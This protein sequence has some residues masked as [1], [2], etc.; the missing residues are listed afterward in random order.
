MSVKSNSFSSTTYA[1]TLELRRPESIRSSPW[2]NEGLE[3]LTRFLSR[4]SSHVDVDGEDVTPVDATHQRYNSSRARWTAQE[5][6]T[7][8]DIAKNDKS[9][10]IPGQQYKPR[11]SPIIVVLRG[12][13]SPR[14]INV[15]K[16]RYEIDPI[17]FQ[18]HLRYRRAVSVSRDFYWPSLP[19]MLP[20]TL[21]LCIA[22]VGR[23]PDSDRDVR[24]LRS[25]ASLGLTRYRHK[26]ITEDLKPGTPIVRHHNVHCPE[27]FSV[28]QEVTIHLT[29]QDQGWFILVQ[30]DIS[31]DLSDPPH[32]PWHA[33]LAHGR[34]GSPFLQTARCSTPETR[35]QFSNA[36]NRRRRSLDASFHQ[37]ALHSFIS[38]GAALDPKL[39]AADP[40]YA[41]SD[42]LRLSTESLWQLLNVIDDVIDDVV[43]HKMSQERRYKA[44]DLL[45]HQD[46]LKRLQNRARS[47]IDCITHY[48]DS[49][50][51]P[52]VGDILRQQCDTHIDSILRDFRCVSNRAADLLN[53]CR[54]DMALCM[55][56]AQIEE[57]RKN[58]EQ[59]K[60]VAQLTLLAFVY[61]PLLFTTSFFGMNVA[62]LGQ[63][64]GL[65]IW[66]WFAMSAPLLFVS[67]ALLWIVEKYEGVKNTLV[68]KKGELSKKCM[69]KRRGENG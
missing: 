1:E 27:F 50:P 66:P 15:V 8:A 5:L 43:G 45:Y 56:A 28:E 53:Q 59:A 22:S 34:G 2:S 38:F 63:E 40:L 14:C 31:G 54:D 6:K 9:P 30:S 18:K 44:E 10:N 60:K 33:P 32:G 20:D 29:R 55:N 42:I 3:D 62:A 52:P 61:I 21:D 26:L 24:E 69:G 47:T 48:K 13:Q 49:W 17:V 7:V 39:M 64:G 36:R 12:F 25:E 67:C 51:R 23:S 19:S 4:E 37:T 16:Q 68:R 65:D 35:R 11:Q 46:I 41:I 58:I 57:S